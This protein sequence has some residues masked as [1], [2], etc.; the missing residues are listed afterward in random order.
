MATI[1]DMFSDYR[2]VERSSITDFLNCFSLKRNGKAILSTETN[3]NDNLSCLYGIRFICMFLLIAVH[4]QYKFAGNV[5]NVGAAMEVVWNQILFLIE[6]L[7]SIIYTESRSLAKSIFDKWFDIR[8]CFFSD[9]RIIGLSV[10]FASV[11][12]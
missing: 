2:P 1:H 11:G 10:V 6:E 8:W 12:P 7:K 3:D 9:E 4:S 5:Y